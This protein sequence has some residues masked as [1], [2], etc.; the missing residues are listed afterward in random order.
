M[1]E[2]FEK[3]GEKFYEAVSLSRD[4]LLYVFE[5]DKKAIKIIK[6]LTDDDLENIAEKYGIALMET[7]E[8]E[9]VLKVAFASRFLE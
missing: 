8:W 2:I 5:G 3:N 1:G 9:G 6:K 4:D 7:A